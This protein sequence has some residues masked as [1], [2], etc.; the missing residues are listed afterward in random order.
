MYL[1]TFLL[2]ILSSYGIRSRGHGALIVAYETASAL[3]VTITPICRHTFRPWWDLAF[4]QAGMHLEQVSRHVFVTT[5]AS[6]MARHLRSL[7]AIYIPFHYTQSCSRRALMTAHTP[8]KM[9]TPPQSGFDSEMRRLTCLP[10]QNLP[11]I[12]FF[13]P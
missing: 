1:F 10:L 4:L 9:D 3:Q 5:D 8:G 7:R 11:I 2:F 13:T 12:S 6:R